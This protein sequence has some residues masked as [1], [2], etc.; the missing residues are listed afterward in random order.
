MG[1]RRSQL[2]RGSIGT[3]PLP[4]FRA[5]PLPCGL[6]GATFL[7][8]GRWG[9]RRPMAAAAGGCAGAQRDG[10]EGSII[11]ATPPP[12]LRAVP[13]P[14]GLPGA[15]FLRTGRWGRR[16]P[17]GAAAGRCA[18]AQ[19]DGS[20]GS[21]IG[22]TPPPPLRAV[23]LPCGLPGAAFLR[24]G[25]WGRRRPM[26][27]AAGR[28][29]GAQ[30]D[31]SEGSIIGATPPPPLRAVPLPCKQGRFAGCRVPAGGGGGD[32]GLRYRRG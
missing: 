30:R 20:E 21:I 25:R 31:G 28:C 22:A 6:P 16:R 23:P 26:G 27:A 29:A 17:M 8:T 13:L 3:S 1:V 10:S 11:G 14:C 5:V 24:T 18:G 32:G 15:A 4:P 19:R 12:P 2:R 7:R 9:R